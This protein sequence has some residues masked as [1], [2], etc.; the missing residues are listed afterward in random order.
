MAHLK[1][2]Y[3]GCMQAENE[4]SITVRLTHCLTGLDLT[5]Q[6]NLMLI[7]HM[8]SHRIQTNKIG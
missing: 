1:N 2:I 6:V 8:L 5:K 7:Q 3:K 4:G